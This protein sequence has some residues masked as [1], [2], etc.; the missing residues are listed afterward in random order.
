MSWTCEVSFFGAETTKRALTVGV[1]ADIGRLCGLS[2][3]S[4]FLPGNASMFDNS[5][6]A[7][8]FFFTKIAKRYTNMSVTRIVNE[9]GD[10]GLE[11]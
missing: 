3:S 5:E 7:R 9:G 6:T 4:G 8:N 2:L 1:D 10:D 11:R